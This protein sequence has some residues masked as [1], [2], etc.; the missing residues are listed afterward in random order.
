VGDAEATAVA[1]LIG[2][3]GSVVAGGL[4]SLAGVGLISLW[5]PQFRRLRFPL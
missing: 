2:P 5:L 3:A 4:L 1:T